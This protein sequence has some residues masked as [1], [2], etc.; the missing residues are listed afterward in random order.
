MQRKK[1]RRN[2]VAY[3]TKYISK[4]KKPKKEGDADNGFFHLAWHNSRGFSS[5]FTGVALTEL[6]ARF[7]GIRSMLNFQKKFSGEYFTWLPWATSMPPD[8]FT[9]MLRTVNQALMYCDS[10]EIQQKL[11]YMYKKEGAPGWD[12]VRPYR[13]Y[14]EENRPKIVRAEKK[15]YSK[16]TYEEKQQ[17]DL[18]HQRT[19]E[20]VSKLPTFDEWKI[21]KNIK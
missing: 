13:K 6:E 10:K 11:K 1:K 8:I 3:I 18:E 5:M 17:F 15:I 16:M 21:S 19:L 20:I 12:A 4:G 14:S 2:L 9:G 7:L